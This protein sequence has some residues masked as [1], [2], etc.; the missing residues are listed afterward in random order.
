[1]SLESQSDEEIWQSIR[2]RSM[3]ELAQEIGRMCLYWSELE[4]TVS[5]FLLKLCDIPDST[6]KNVIFGALDFRSKLHALLPMAFSKKPD[7]DW[8]ARVE[9]VVNQ[10][11]NDLRAER[12]RIIHDSWIEMP[13]SDG[14][15]RM[16]IFGRVVNAQSR[17]KKLQLADYRPFTPKDVGV[18]YVQMIRA[19]QLIEQLSVE[20]DK[21]MGSG[22]FPLPKK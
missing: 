13:G 18:L 3:D 11:D 10:I 2:H 12:N 14:P 7:D 20:H 6:T 21:R 22:V 17:T 1:M 4:T 15:H 9:K 16:R 19:R 8:Y 5:L